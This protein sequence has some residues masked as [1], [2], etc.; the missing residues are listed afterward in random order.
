MVSPLQARVKMAAHGEV[1]LN[2][3]FKE[4]FKMQPSVGKVMCIV[5]W[6]RKRMNIVDFLEPGHTVKSDHYIVMLAKLK[7]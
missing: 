5:F 2:S 6:G 3:I 1:T 4:E 7:A